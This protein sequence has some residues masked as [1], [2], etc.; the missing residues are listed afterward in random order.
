MPESV[1]SDKKLLIVTSIVCGI[2]ARVVAR[3]W[4][5]VFCQDALLHCLPVVLTQCWLVA[6]LPAPLEICFPQPHVNVVCVCV[7]REN[8]RGGDGIAAVYGIYQAPS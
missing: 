3:L 7:L 2:F 8:A 6:Q 1:D 4:C 5:D